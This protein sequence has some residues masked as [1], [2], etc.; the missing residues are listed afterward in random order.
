MTV[1]VS[2]AV[3]RS[4]GFRD[5]VQQEAQE[6]RVDGRTFCDGAGEGQLVA[7]NS[8]HS[9]HISVAIRVELGVS[10]DILHMLPMWR[11]QPGDLPAD[12]CA[13]QFKQSMK[14][15]TQRLRSQSIR[16]EGRHWSAHLGNC[17]AE[18]CAGQGF[19]HDFVSSLN[20]RSNGLQRVASRDAGAPA[21]AAA[22]ALSA[23]LACHQTCFIFKRCMHSQRHLSTGSKE[24]ELL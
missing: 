18:D 1:T 12:A 8:P 6:L 21:P 17:L 10:R 5:S 23:C 3:Q 24:A 22:Q 11:A 14:N 9:R 15:A 19:Q 13:Q 16:S 20:V 4:A 7:G 2:N